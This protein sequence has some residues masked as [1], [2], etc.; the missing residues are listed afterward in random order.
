MRHPKPTPSSP[1]K[2]PGSRRWCY[3]EADGSFHAIYLVTAV[4]LIACALVL[5]SLMS[6]R[7]GAPNQATHDRVGSDRGNRR[8]GQ[9]RGLRARNTRAGPKRDLRL[10]PRRCGSTPAAGHRNGVDRIAAGTWATT[11]RLGDSFGPTMEAIP[12][13]PSTTNWVSATRYC[14]LTCPYADADFPLRRRIPSGAAYPGRVHAEPRGSVHA[15]GLAQPLLTS[16]KLSVANGRLWPTIDP[17][18]RRLTAA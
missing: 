16:R 4:H 14:T 15:G 7:G 17:C 5:A 18:L 2:S 3:R 13:S 8:D 6:R 12:R 11:W 1:N 9:P 10:R